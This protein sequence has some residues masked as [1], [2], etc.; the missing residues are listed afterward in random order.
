MIITVQIV[1]YNSNNNHDEILRSETSDAERP[2][3]SFRGG[4]RVDD[5]RRPA[6]VGP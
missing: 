2:P 4:I 1:L 6:K 5:R 3:S